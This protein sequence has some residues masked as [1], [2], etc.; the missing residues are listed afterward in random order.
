MKI[1]ADF[2]TNSSSTAYV[3]FIPDDFDLDE[4]QVK[5]IYDKIKSTNLAKYGCTCA[6][7]NKDILERIKKNN[8]KKYGVEWPLQN[9]D[10]LH[11][12]QLN[13]LKKKKFKKWKK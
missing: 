5:E 2:V 6:L 10:I 3:V 8:I 12:Q 4:D 11:K 7:H 1:K 9:S 13:S